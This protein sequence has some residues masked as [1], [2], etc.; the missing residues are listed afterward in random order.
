ME[1]GVV[2]GSPGRGGVPGEV[3]ESVDFLG[4]VGGVVNGEGFRRGRGMATGREIVLAVGTVGSGQGGWALYIV[5]AGISM[6]ESLFFSFHGVSVD[7]R[8]RKRE[9]VCVCVC[10]CLERGFPPGVF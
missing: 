4:G 3:A 2:V 6:K 8:D 7:C 10:V 5:C 9:E 1:K